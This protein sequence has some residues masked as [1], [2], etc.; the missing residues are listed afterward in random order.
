MDK[1]VSFVVTVPREAAAFLTDPAQDLAARAGCLAELVESRQAAAGGSRVRRGQR[2][3]KVLAVVPAD[4]AYQLLA[5]EPRHR[6]PQ[7]ARVVSCEAFL[8]CSASLAAPDAP[9]V[10][11]QGVPLDQVRAAEASV[12]A[13]EGLRYAPV[14]QLAE[15][16]R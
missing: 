6:R 3:V 4:L 14:G 10:A 13:L 12:A 5:D 16:G 8:F 9:A 15:I 7:L 2:A 11:Y 1:G